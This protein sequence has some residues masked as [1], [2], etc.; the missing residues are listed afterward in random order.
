VLY[1]KSVEKANKIGDQILKADLLR[2]EAAN[3]IKNTTETIEKF[4]L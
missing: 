3:L 1:P 2:Y 4:I